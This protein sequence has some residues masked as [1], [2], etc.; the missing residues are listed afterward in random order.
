MHKQPKLWCICS[1]KVTTVKLNKRRVLVSLLHVTATPL[2]RRWSAHKLGYRSAVGQSYADWVRSPRTLAQRVGSLV[3]TQ[4]NGTLPIFSMK[5]APVNSIRK[6]HVHLRRG[7]LDKHTS[8]GIHTFREAIQHRPLLALLEC[9]VLAG[10]APGP[11]NKLISFTATLARGGWEGGRGWG[12]CLEILTCHFPSCENAVAA[13]WVS[14]KRRM[15]AMCGKDNLSYRGE[16]T[17]MIEVPP[18]G[19]E[20][21]ISRQS[22]QQKPLHGRVG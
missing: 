19:W 21:V 3:S 8:M 17:C 11:L 7:W 20:R 6:P 2:A 12:R 18:A 4:G 16:I 9:S 14:I 15:A 1:L 13:E 5:R 22:N 10:Q